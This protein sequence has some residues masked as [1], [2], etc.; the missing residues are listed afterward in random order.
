MDSRTEWPDG[1][2]RLVDKGRL[3][4]KVFG[5]FIRK[6]YDYMF[7]NNPSEVLARSSGAQRCIDTARILSSTITLIPNVNVTVDDRLLRDPPPNCPALKVIKERAYHTDR[8]EDFV[9]K[10]KK[11]LEKV[12]KGAG[13]KVDNINDAYEI[14]DTLK[15][16]KE[17][18][19]T[20]PSWATPEIYW[21][22]NEIANTYGC[23]NS[24][25]EKGIALQLGLFLSDLEKQLDDI[26][27]G[28]SSRRLLV[29]TTHDTK[30]AMLQR[31]LNAFNKDLPAPYAAA[32]VFELH[33][34][35]LTGKP[36]VLSYYNYF[37]DEMKRIEIPAAP[38]SCKKQTLCPLNQFFTSLHRFMLNDKT[39]DQECKD[40]TDSV[41]ML[42]HFKE[43]FK[44]DYLKTHKKSLLDS[45]ESTFSDIFG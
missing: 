30:I 6:R 13:K 3:K 25:S 26:S 37:N 23:V 7:T 12:S 22:L 11:L 33:E 20:L 24:A 15:V 32:I 44:S 40:T 4:A 14:F 1:E 17:N 19:K 18:N 34:D 8:A 43:C 35:V 31:L 10:N 27:A 16:E 9:K 41:D 45:I 28:K 36:S 39:L 21:A 38:D 29:Y 42:Q 5:E 2:A